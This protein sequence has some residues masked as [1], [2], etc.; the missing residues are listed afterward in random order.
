MPEL[1]EVECLRRSL[2]PHLAGRRIVGVTVRDGRLREP[3]REAAL[4]AL[5]PA[6]VAAVERRAKVLLVRLASGAALLVHLGM[7]GRLLVEPASAPWRPHDRLRLHLEGGDR[8]VYHDPRRFGRVV[9]LA[10]GEGHP[11]LAGLGP[12]PL[13]EGFGG[14]HLAR[15]ARGRRR[16]VKP[17]LMDGRVVAGVGN[18]YA[19]E[20]CFAA[21][22]HPAAPAGR[23]SAARWERLAAALRAVL[24]ESIAAGG[25]T[26]RDFADAE[27]RGG[28]YQLRT[29]VYG[30][31]GEPCVACGRPI[32]RL[33]Q[34]GRSTFYC[35]RCQRW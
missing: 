22:I 14:A 6:R 5:L 27:G 16:P 15:A 28:L 34:S 10:P 25:T 35:P 17:F 24:A 1:P 11:L 29:R 12:E 26:L 4:A 7:S 19:C 3:V 30:R 23:L 2:A 31:E 21:G 32:R 9:A 8:L 20:A 13:G 33:T 18:I